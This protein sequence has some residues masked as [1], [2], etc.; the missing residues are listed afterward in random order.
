[1]YTM[2]PNLF[3]IDKY[4]EALK[5]YAFLQKNNVIPV[6]GRSDELSKYNPKNVAKKIG[7]KGGMGFVPYNVKYAE[8]TYEGKISDYFGSLKVGMMDQEQELFVRGINETIDRILYKI[9]ELQIR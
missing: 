9:E 3:Q 2:L 7:E 8:H 6:L 4:L 1:M 5:Q